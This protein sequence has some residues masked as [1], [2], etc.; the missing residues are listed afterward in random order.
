MSGGRREPGSGPGGVLGKLDRLRVE[1]AGVYEDAYKLIQVDAASDDQIATTVAGLL[2][3]LR[4]LVADTEDTLEAA[5]TLP[6]P[7][8]KKR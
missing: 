4:G 1:A 8:P 7:R 5:S 3:N 2:K 6:R